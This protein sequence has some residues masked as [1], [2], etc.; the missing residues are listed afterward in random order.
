MRKVYIQLVVKLLSSGVTIMAAVYGASQDQKQLDSVVDA[1]VSYPPG[2]NKFY[3]LDA[4]LSS[5]ADGAS[6]RNRSMTR[7]CTEI[8][9]DI[10]CKI[11][12]PL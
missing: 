7:L 2:E 1:V 11:N 4:Q 9:G 5:S 8:P 12:F 10:P 3:F 6:Q